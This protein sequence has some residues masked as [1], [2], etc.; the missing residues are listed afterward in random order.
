MED[1]FP[2]FIS[3]SKDQA[4]STRGKSKAEAIDLN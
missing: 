1:S 4:L 3:L 2:I